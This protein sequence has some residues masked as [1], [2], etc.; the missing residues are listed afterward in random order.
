MTNDL[1][2]NEAETPARLSSTCVATVCL[3][4]KVPFPIRQQFKMYAAQRNMT[5]TEL[6]LQM[7]HYYLTSDTKSQPN[8]EIKK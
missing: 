4:F 5:M 1:S 6:L 3:N 7:F 8:I 2:R